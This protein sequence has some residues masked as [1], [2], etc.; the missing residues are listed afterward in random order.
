MQCSNSS[1]KCPADCLTTEPDCV[2]MMINLGCSPRCC[3]VYVVYLPILK[4]DFPGGMLMLKMTS[5]KPGIAQK[6]LSLL[7]MVKLVLLFTLPEKMG[8]SPGVAAGA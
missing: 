6:M 3:Y 1:F 4:P 7:V 5:P 2:H 8:I